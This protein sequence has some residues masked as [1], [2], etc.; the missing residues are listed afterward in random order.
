MNNRSIK[1]N[2]SLASFWVTNRLSNLKKGGVN[3]KGRHM[4][5]RHWITCNC[6][7][8]KK[9]CKDKVRK[10]NSDPGRFR[11]DWILKWHN[12]KFHFKMQDSELLHPSLAQKLLARDCATRLLLEAILLVMNA[13]QFL[14]WV[15]PPVWK[16]EATLM[17]PYPW[18]PFSFSLFF[19]S[20]CR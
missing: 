7:I 5:L 15:S 19:Q 8:G 2:K 11:S 3:G 12:Y 6:T 18:G 17:G 1:V 10:T 4:V 9:A 14:L 16:V 13:W 20:I